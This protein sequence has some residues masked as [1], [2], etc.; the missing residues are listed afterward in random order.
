VRGIQIQKKGSIQL[1]NHTFDNL[2][3]QKFK[4][5]LYE[6]VRHF[7]TQE[8]SLKSLKSH[9]DDASIYNK[10]LGRK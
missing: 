4:P 7:L 9:I 10:M 3:E 8:V 5:G 2:L 1:E 6:Q